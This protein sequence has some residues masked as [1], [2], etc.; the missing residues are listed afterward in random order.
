[1]PLPVL[2]DIRIAS[3]CDVPWESMQGDGRVR[4]CGQCRLNVYDLSGMTRAE[5]EAL[6]AKG[7]AAGKLP[8][9]Q[10]WR[11]ADGTILTQDCPPAREIGR[12]HV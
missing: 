5:G 8:C 7:L 12:A 6:I 3:P 10:L 11:R 2:E 1:M 9:V 4:F